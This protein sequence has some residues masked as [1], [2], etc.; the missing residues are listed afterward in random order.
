MKLKTKFTKEAKRVHTLLQ[1]TLELLDL[2][3][4]HA[5]EAE[6][7]DLQSLKELGAHLTDYHFPGA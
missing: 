5:E 6:E 2:Q 1:E 4:Q 7:S 3:I